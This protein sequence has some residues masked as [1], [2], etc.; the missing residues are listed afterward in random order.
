LNN[1]DENNEKNIVWISTYV[2]IQYINK[3]R[4]TYCR[5]IQFGL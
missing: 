2:L 3:K 5:S 1:E 4:Y